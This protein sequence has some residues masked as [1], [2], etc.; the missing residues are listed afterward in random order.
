MQ[1]SASEN[2]S[3]LT[4]DFVDSGSRGVEGEKQIVG[5]PLDEVP[6]MVILP[7]GF[8]LGAVLDHRPAQQGHGERHREVELYVVAGVVVATDEAALHVRQVG[9]VRQA[10]VPAPRDAV[11]LRKPAGCHREEGQ[12]VRLILQYP[13]F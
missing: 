5:A 6:H 7:N 4:V 3:Y 11:V 13:I 8:V 10:G 9:A 2:L 12:D 1:F